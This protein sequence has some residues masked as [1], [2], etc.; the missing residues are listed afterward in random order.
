MDLFEQLYGEVKSQ[1]AWLT[2]PPRQETAPNP[3]G[4]LVSVNVRN[5]AAPIL[6]AE[7]CENLADQLARRWRKEHGSEIIHGVFK[8]KWAGSD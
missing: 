7:G 1:V 2:H 8:V 3:A 5:V 6:L 4:E